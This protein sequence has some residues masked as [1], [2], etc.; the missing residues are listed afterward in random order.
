MAKTKPKVAETDTTEADLLAVDKLP[1]LDLPPPIYA[2]A[3]AA[4]REA[5]GRPHDDTVPPEPEDGKREQAPAVG[6]ATSPPAGI[7]ETPAADAGSL[8]AARDRLKREAGMTDA[9]VLS[10]NDDQVFER[11]NAIDRKAAIAKREAERVRI[12]GEEAA[13]R[14]IDFAAN[15]NGPMVVGDSGYNRLERA[16][17]N[18][19]L[20]VE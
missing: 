1:P 19:A 11:L 9:Q 4:A 18:P 2:E 7:T 12:Q 17:A 10:M 16:A 13:A 5:A 6:E 14:A 15:S 20:P 8:A 3:E